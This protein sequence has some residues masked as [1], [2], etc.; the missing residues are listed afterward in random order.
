MDSFSAS[1]GI[2][3]VHGGG[4]EWGGPRED[5]YD[6]LCSRL[7]SGSGSFRVAVRG[8]KGAARSTEEQVCFLPTNQW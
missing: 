7:A 3:F 1:P 6:S 2:F 5:G 4:F 8:M